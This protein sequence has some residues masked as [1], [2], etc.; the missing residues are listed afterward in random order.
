MADKHHSRIVKVELLFGD[1]NFEKGDLF[2]RLYEQEEF[3]D[4][5]GVKVRKLEVVK[6]YMESKGQENFTNILKRYRAKNE[7]QEDE[8]LKET[9]FFYAIIG[10]MADLMNEFTRLRNGQDSALQ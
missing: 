2:F 10:I 5:F 7:V 1:F 8:E 3:P 4:R 6:T 9:V